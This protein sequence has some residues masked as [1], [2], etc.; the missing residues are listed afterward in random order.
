MTEYIRVLNALPHPAA[1]ID[2]EHQIA[3]ANRAFVEATGFSTSAR[4]GDLEQLSDTPHERERWREFVLSPPPARLEA[5]RCGGKPLQTATLNSLDDSGATMLMLEETNALFTQNA[6]ERA[7]RRMRRVVWQ[8]RTED[9]INQVLAAVRQGLLDAGLPLIGLSVNVVDQDSSTHRVTIHTIME[10]RIVP[11]ELPSQTLCEWWRAGTVLYRP[12]LRKDDPFKELNTLLEFYHKPILCVIDVPFQ[13]GTIG[14]NSDQPN[15]FSPAHIELIREIAELLSDGFTRAEELR[16]LQRDNI[17]LQET[18]RL[19]S[20]FEEIGNTITSSLELDEVLDTISNG[21]VRAGIFRSLMIALVDEDRGD[22]EVV[23]GYNLEAT[24]G[25]PEKKKLAPTA[26]RLRRIPLDS[27][28]I[29][30]DVART[31]EIEII[32]GWDSRFDPDLDPKQTYD[33]DKVAYFI[34]IKHKGEVIG[35]LATGSNR[36]QRA[37]MEKRIEGMRSLI[38]LAGNAVHHAQLYAE[39]LE[40]RVEL[41]EMN[42]R[43]EQRVQDRTAQLRGMNDELRR[44]NKELQQFAYVASHDLREPL[45]TIR[46]FAQLIDRRYRDALDERGREWLRMMVEGAMRMTLQL[47][48]MLEYSRVNTRGGEFVATKGDAVLNAAIQSLNAA[49]GSSG[50]KITQDP[51]PT[52]IVDPQQMER[53]LQNLIH[54]AIK[55]RRDDPPRIH[56]SATQTTN[57]WT[58][59]VRDE[60]IGIEET[61]YERI[62]VIYQQ[63]HGRGEYEGIGMGLAVC[64]RIVE[65]HGGRIWVESVVGEGSTFYVSLPNDPNRAA[66]LLG[67]PPPS[68]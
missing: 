60:G 57:G 39:V 30:A 22:L 44:S 50:A 26:A 34:P 8:M 32:V 35:V 54:N 41:A 21:V 36:D 45:R 67:D 25:E 20:A 56:I 4:L 62:F 42:A 16:E 68:T 10:D 33:P 38:T 18:I 47:D 19:L 49:I 13:Y 1:I 58:F 53:V 52:I 11:I 37:D 46:N 12:D 14:V 17:E 27:P 63:L 31:G 5:W 3:F 28:D 61:F 40:S 2:Q 59:A 51:L 48:A 24:P 7:V 15:A 23:R 9:D 66:E 6:R 64:K 43:L 55:Y 65:R 29:V